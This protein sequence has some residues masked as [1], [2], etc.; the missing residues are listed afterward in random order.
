MMGLRVF[1]DACRLAWTVRKLPRD[2][3][4]ALIDHRYRTELYKASGLSNHEAAEAAMA[5]R[6]RR[7]GYFT[8]NT[9]A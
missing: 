3:R 4:A 5:D 2:A 9:P 7:R 6:H 8:R 1:L